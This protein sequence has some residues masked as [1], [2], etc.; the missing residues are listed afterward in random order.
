MTDTDTKIA[1]TVM[2]RLEVPEELLEAIM[3]TAFDGD[4]GGCWYW[5]QPAKLDDGESWLEVR[6]RVGRD[7]QTEDT[8]WLSAKITDAEYADP[9]TP[10]LHVTYATL[11]LGMQRMLDE[12][13]THSYWSHKAP[14]IQQAILD[15]DGGMIDADLADNIVQQGLFDKQIYS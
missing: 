12:N 15:S 6:H 3:V 10:V 2:T 8:A 13:L 11:V 1:Y 5:A 4:Y 14:I 7:E 9:G